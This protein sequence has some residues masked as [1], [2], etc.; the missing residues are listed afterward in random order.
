MYFIENTRTATCKKIDYEFYCAELFIVKY[1]TKYICESAIYFD[2]DA[3]KIKENCEL[4]YYFNKTDMKPA[5]L[6]GGHGIVLANWP[7]NKHV[8]C[9][10][11]NNISIK[12]PS[13]PYVLVNRTVLCNCG[14]EV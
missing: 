8:V 11:N 5:V 1:K 13:H 14:I 7:N 10:D 4:Q 6:H 2:L 3:E 9:N 12:I